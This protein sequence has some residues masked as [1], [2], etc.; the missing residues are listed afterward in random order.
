MVYGFKPYSKVAESKR[1]VTIRSVILVMDDEPDSAHLLGMILGMHFPHATV[2][3]AHG[4]QA[5]STSP[6]GSGRS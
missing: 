5:R 2:G 6:R 4:A 1:F 3:V